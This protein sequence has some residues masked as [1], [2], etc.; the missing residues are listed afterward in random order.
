MQLRF[1]RLA[2]AFGDLTAFDIPTLTIESGEF[3][4]F[5]G[6]VN[7]G[8][9]TVLKVIAGLEAPSAGTLTAGDRVLNDVAPGDRGV[10]L[11]ASDRLDPSP[12]PVALFDEPTL[13][14]GASQR[15]SIVEELKRLHTQLGTTFICATADESEALALSDRIAVLK[16]GVVQQVG[17]P[18]DV[19]DRPANI[20]VAGF[21]G[22]PPMNV[23]P[24]ILEKDGVAV[25]IGPRAL[26]LNGVIAEEYAR[27]VFLGV[28]PEYVRLRPA[29]TPGWPG[30]VTRVES[31]ADRTVIEVHVDGGD[32]VAREHGE[33]RYQV[34]DRVSIAMAPK[35]LYVFDAPGD[36][37]VVR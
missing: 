19:F 24:G 16:D 11:M 20:V 23:V 3:F 34:G 9:S 26:Q 28:R 15:A 17:T 30:R 14:V 13:R 25:E 18:A 27:D 37:L 32:F 1:D 35:H 10:M 5:A 7:S 33:S 31:S 6:A 29:P 21:F 4:T 36:R 22:N 2:K 8:K 12:Y